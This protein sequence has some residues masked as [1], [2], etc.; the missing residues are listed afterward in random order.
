MFAYSTSKWA[1]R[2]A[3]RSAAQDLVGSGIR[4]NLVMPGLID[5]PMV[6]ETASPDALQR[7]R[8]AVPMARAGLPHEVAEA[9]LYLASDAAAFI[10][11]SELVIDGGVSA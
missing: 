6:Q 8:D 7:S 3:S 11:G 1:L 4:V 2:G 9:V 10:T 5:T